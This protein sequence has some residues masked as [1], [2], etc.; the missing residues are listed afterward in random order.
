[1]AFIVLESMSG[2][3]CVLYFLVLDLGTCIKVKNKTV[4]EFLLT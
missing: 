3:L 2:A 4:C 1:M